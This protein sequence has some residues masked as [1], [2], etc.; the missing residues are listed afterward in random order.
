MNGYIGVFKSVNNRGLCRIV[1][2]VIGFYDDNFLD[3]GERRV[4][5]FFGSRDGKDDINGVFRFYRRG[6]E[7]DDKLRRFGF[8][9][10]KRLLRL[11]SEFEERKVDRFVGGNKFGFGWRFNIVVIG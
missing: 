9:V 7:V 3:I 4:E 10:D 8:V 5:F 11:M 1:F 6:E 2:V